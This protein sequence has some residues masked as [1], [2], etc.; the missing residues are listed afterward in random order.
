MV[1]ISKMPVLLYC[2]IHIT[3]RSDERS[4]PGKEARDRKM[5]LS[6]KAGTSRSRAVW[7]KLFLSTI[8]KRQRRIQTKKARSVTSCFCCIRD[9]DYLTGYS[10]IRVNS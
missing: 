2:E 3:I 8:L 1:F 9:M 7:K 4:L 6:F 10:T 5:S